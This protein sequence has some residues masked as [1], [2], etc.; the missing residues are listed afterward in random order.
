MGQHWLYH[1]PQDKIKAACSYC[2]KYY[3]KNSVII[4]KKNKQKSSKYH[5]CPTNISADSPS[6]SGFSVYMNS[7]QMHPWQEDLASAEAALA[8]IIGGVEGIQQHLRVLHGI[9]LQAMGTGEE[10]KIY[11]K[12]IHVDQ[13]TTAGMISTLTL[14]IQEPEEFVTVYEG[15]IESDEAA[16]AM[17]DE[18]SIFSYQGI[19]YNMPAKLYIEPPFYC[20]LF[21]E[22]R[23]FIVPSGIGSQP[24]DDPLL[25]LVRRQSE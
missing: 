5:N 11:L 6:H 7:S 16:Y 15:S 24:V 2:K 12:V 10:L 18:C 21:W 8:D 1:T 3:A 19:F 4:S 17:A 22:N 9:V 14:V 13:T 20:S 25:Y 23:K